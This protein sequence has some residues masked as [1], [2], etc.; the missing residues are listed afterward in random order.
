MENILEDVDL[1]TPAIRL[2]IQQKLS[3]LERKVLV[4]AARCNLADQFTFGQLHRES[5]I[6]QSGQ[7]S[8][9]VGRL[10]KKGFFVKLGKGVYDFASEDLRLHLRYR[11]C[12]RK[13][14]I[15]LQA[16]DITNSGDAKESE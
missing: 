11:H 5:R 13:P 2:Q 6:V 16:N 8:V 7:L 15:S 10:V 9:I 3:P 1:K 14:F 4:V 12:G